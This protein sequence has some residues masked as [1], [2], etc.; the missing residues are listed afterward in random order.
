MLFVNDSSVTFSMGHPLY[1]FPI[2]RWCRFLIQ[3]YPIRSN[4][5]LFVK[6]YYNVWHFNINK[7]MQIRRL[8]Q[9]T[10]IVQVLN[11]PAAI[12]EYT[13]HNHDRSPQFPR[14]KTFSPSQ[15]LCSNFCINSS[16]KCHCYSSP[17]MIYFNILL[18]T[19][20]LFFSY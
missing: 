7:V 4:L 2:S 10:W 16:Q 3:F 5:D 12:L 15:L 8:V 1:I 20:K 14:N 18:Q 6:L 19:L 11:T 17:Y 13:T 9:H